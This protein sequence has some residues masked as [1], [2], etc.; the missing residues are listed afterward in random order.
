MDINYIYTKIKNR[1][2]YINGWEDMKRASVI[3]P[4]VKVKDRLCILFEVRSRTLRKQP[5]DVCFPGGGIE[6][7]ET[8][9]EAALRETEEELGLKSIDIIKE[10][11]VLVRYNGLILH[12]FLGEVKDLSE[13][14]ISK[15]EVESVFYVPIDELLKIKP[16][17]AK[18]RLIAEKPEDFPYNL[19]VGGK[20]YK[21]LEGVYKSIFYK[22]ENHV[23]WGITAAILENFINIIK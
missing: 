18:S 12:S 22:Y 19:V 2:S 23:I 5:G 11:D 16:I 9:E 3:V 14:N 15:D 4:I 21:F 7:N 10:L 13:L 8:P 1:E 17:V 20:N 6:V